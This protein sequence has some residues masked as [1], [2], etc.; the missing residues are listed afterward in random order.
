M[1]EKI[2]SVSGMHVVD[3]CGVGTDETGFDFRSRYR[4]EWLDGR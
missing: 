2:I 3:A 4:Y 1:Y